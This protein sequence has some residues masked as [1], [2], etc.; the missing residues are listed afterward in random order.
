MPQRH[1]LVRNQQNLLKQ[2]AK[3][4]DFDDSFIYDEIGKTTDR[5]SIPSI[6]LMHREAQVAFTDW[7]NKTDKIEY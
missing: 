2:D 6:A 5:R 4:I 1:L 3:V 7:M